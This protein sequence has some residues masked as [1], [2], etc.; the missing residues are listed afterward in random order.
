MIRLM[1]AVSLLALL[2]ACGDGNPLFD[3]DGNPLAPS[4]T[5][6]DT[7]GDADVDPREGDIDNDGA[8]PPPGT[9]D[10]TLDSSIF[11]FEGRDGEGGGLVTQ[12]S[13]NRSADTFTVDN[14]AFDGANVYQR[15]DPI[16][17]LNGYRVFAADETTDD[18]LT[19]NAVSQIVPYRAIYGVSGE[20][21]SGDPRTSFA[22]V[23]TGGYIGHGFGGYVYERTGGATLPESGQAT[24]SGDYGGVWT[25]DGISDLAYVQGDMTM[26][27]DFAD[28][29][30]NAGVKGRVTNRILIDE[31]GANLGAMPNINWVVEEGV[32]TLNENG[33]INTQVFT[34]RIDPDSGIVPFFQGTFSGLLAG[35]LTDRDDGGEIVGIIEMDA[36]A[37]VTPGSS[38]DAFTGNLVPDDPDGTT[39]GIKETGGAILSRN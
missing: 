11:R 5:E 35:D 27:I 14:L 30:E 1:S 8:T 34:Q 7:T 38:L 6:T 33:E 23:R 36:T 10:P 13:Y 17:T 32:M 16:A 31:S 29:N 3:E 24:F 21:V 15:N 18:F 37:N 22:I 25:F 2:A 9:E 39:I 19:G 26:D 4:G 28:F 20:R 12:V